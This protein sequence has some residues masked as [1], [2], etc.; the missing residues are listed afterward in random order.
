LP[1]NQLLNERV[2]GQTGERA[3]WLH[4]NVNHV[5]GYMKLQRERIRRILLSRLRFMGD[6]ILTTPLIRRLR[7]FFPEAKIC[8]LTE[9]AYAPLL[10]HN[11][12]LDEVIPFPLHGGLAAQ[13][14][15]HRQLRRRRFDLAI[16]LFGNPRT[17]LLTWLTGAP[18]R[19]GGDFRGRGKLYNIRVAAPEN[20]LNA[21]DFHWR[22]LEALGIDKGDHRTEIFLTEQERS[23]ARAFLEEN[24]IDWSRPV[25]GLHPGATWPNKR[26]PEKYFAELAHRLRDKGIQVVITQ[27][28]GE[29]KIVTEVMR[30]RQPQ[31]PTQLLAEDRRDAEIILLPVLTLRQLAGVQQQMQAF[32]SNDCG[33]MHLAVAAGTPTIGLFGPS[34]PQV[35]F[36]Y[37]RANGHVAM[38]QEIDCRPCHKNFCPLGHLNCQNQL[39]PERVAAVALERVKIRS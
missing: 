32:V 13:W 37:Q 9:E 25:V 38:L 39:L 8:Y 28:P 11:P 10:L 36:P 20:E 3:N 18:F 4:S 31:N 35:W 16:D 14:Q 34:Q 2:N 30:Q 33:V 7:E 6:V 12:N 24:L 27:G 15:A 21:I 23:R 19:V 17:A 22:S 5:N 29:E 26:W 1:V